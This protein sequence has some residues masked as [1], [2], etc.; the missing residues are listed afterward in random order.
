MPVINN[1]HRTATIFQSHT[2][3]N[4]VQMA[5]HMH[6]NQYHAPNGAI[7]SIQIKCLPLQQVAQD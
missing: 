3:K 6:T 1:Y 7:K 4:G 2:K 5:T